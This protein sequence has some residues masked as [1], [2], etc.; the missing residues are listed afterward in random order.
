MYVKWGGNPF[1]NIR[2]SEQTHM[3]RMK[4][5]ITTYKLTDPVDNN[6]DKHGVFT[7]ALLQK[8]YN[9]LVTTGSQSLTEALKT[10]AK[11]EE[12]E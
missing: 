7:N 1:G 5:L 12:V 8:Y 9:D 3:N 6:K 4:N 2:R 10:G 11:I